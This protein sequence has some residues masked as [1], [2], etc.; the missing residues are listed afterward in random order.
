MLSSFQCEFSGRLF[1]SKDSTLNERWTGFQNGLAVQNNLLF[2]IQQSDENAASKAEN[3]ACKTREWIQLTR[4][5]NNVT[6]QL[7]NWM[8][9]GGTVHKEHTTSKRIDAHFHDMDKMFT[10]SSSSLHWCFLVTFTLTCALGVVVDAAGSAARNTTTAS[11]VEI[12]RFTEVST[13][14]LDSSGIVMNSRN[15]LQMD[16]GIDRKKKRRNRTR[17]TKWW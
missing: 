4:H 16:N 13:H 8:H 9:T 11:G 3:E 6:T 15:K 10:L 7:Q 12:S 1:V 2:Q 17:G 5:R 14:P